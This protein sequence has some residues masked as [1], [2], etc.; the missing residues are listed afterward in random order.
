MAQCPFGGVTS[1]QKS[2]VVELV[3]DV[4][5]TFFCYS[6]RSSTSSIFDYRWVD[7][8]EARISTDLRKPHT[9][10]AAARSTNRKIFLHIGPTNSGKTH[11]ALASLEAS[12]HGTY[13]GPL[14]LLA[15]EV[16]E[17][18]T[19]AKVRC[20]LVT[21]QEIH[22]VDDATH[23]SSTVEMLDI[24]EPYDCAVIDEIQMIADETRGWA[25]TQALMGANAKEVHLCGSEASEKLVR[26]LCK[27]MGE[28]LE[29]L[30]YQRLTP[31]E[32]AKHP[33]NGLDDIRAG[34]C[35]VGFSRRALYQL[36]RQ[37]EHA[38][39]YKHKCC[40]V[41]GSLPAEARRQQ[42]QL[43]NDS[44]S[45]YDVL[46]ASDAIGMG[47]NLRIRRIVFAN[48]SKFDGYENRH[49][50]P[51]EIQQIGGRA[52]RYGMSAKGAGDVGVVTSLNR[53]L[54]LIRRG[55][56]KPVAPLRCAG[57]FPLSSQL[58]LHREE[59]KYMDSSLMEEDLCLFNVLL[60]FSNLAELDKHF[61]FCNIDEVLLLAEKLAIHVKGLTLDDSLTLS[62]APVHA[63]NDDCMRF[64]LR[65]SD[66]VRRGKACHLGI[67]VNVD[68]QPPNTPQTI[69]VVETASKI[70]EMYVWLGHRFSH[71]FPDMDLAEEARENCSELIETGLHA[72]TQAQLKQYLHTKKKIGKFRRKKKTSRKM[73]RSRVVS[74]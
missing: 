4:K 7:D 46:V 69:E 41:Y 11:A 8:N 29:V 25:W 57:V 66:R 43:F 36:K 54:G 35:V 32:T 71:L 13:C 59:M 58:H 15:W 2:L 26:H 70:A 22:E 74:Q 16:Y 52:G 65:Y 33:L 21:G 67:K 37:I 19:E 61:F 53:D 63:H 45:G 10:Y 23:V 40:V 64:W 51:S 1:K 17:R 38:S 56:S 49:L 28:E 30:R 60:S 24:A 5:G 20:N 55:L 6:S 3:F 44:E 62:M 34:D 9:W 48:T 31:L 73:R 50:F 47:L 14:R 42:A 72:L 27:S 68:R 18:L 39:Q 12:E